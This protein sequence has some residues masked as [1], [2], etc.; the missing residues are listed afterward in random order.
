MKERK[1]EQAQ[2]QELWYHFRRSSMFFCS[3]PASR[4]RSSTLPRSISCWMYSG[5]CPSRSN[6]HKKR[7][8]PLLP[9][10]NHPNCLRRKCSIHWSLR[11]Y[12]SHN[13]RRYPMSYQSS[14]HH[15]SCRRCYLHRSCHHRSHH[16]SF[17]HSCHHRSCHHRSCHYQ[18]YHNCIRHRHN[19]P[20]R[21]RHHN[22]LDPNRCCH[23]CHNRHHNYPDPNRC[24]RYCRN[25]H[26]RNHNRHC[27]NYHRRNH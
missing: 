27:R 10:W 14:C 7:R 22:Y 16:R 13:H 11:C 17:H 8:N 5:W 25:R 26:H 15:R 9:L 12:H 21:N 4:C 3:S 6:Q 18:K 19:C 24:C 23:Y 20:D 2:E 1:Q